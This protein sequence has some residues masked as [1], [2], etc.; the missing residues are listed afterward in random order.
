MADRDD[1]DEE[2]YGEEYDDGEEYGEEGEEEEENYEDW[3]IEQILKH[4]KDKEVCNSLCSTIVFGRGAAR[5]YAEPINRQPR[6]W[7]NGSDLTNLA[8]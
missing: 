3:V 5:S 2:E 7:S 8:G 1:Y 6:T 4:K